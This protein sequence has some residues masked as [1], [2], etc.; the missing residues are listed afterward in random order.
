MFQDPVPALSWDPLKVDHDDFSARTEGAEDAGI[1]LRR[2][3]EVV[4]SIAGAWATAGMG[5]PRPALTSATRSLGRI[6]SAS[7][8][9]SLEANSSR[10][11]ASRS[12]RASGSSVMKRRL[13]S[14]GG[15]DFGS[16]SAWAAEVERLRAMNKSGTMRV[17]AGSF[18]IGLAQ[19]AKLCL[20]VGG[21]SFDG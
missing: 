4:V 20:S 14:D 11:S 7:M 21:G 16:F 19:R 8:I 15:S 5:A 10:L 13:I 2:V 3:L 17:M 12:S 9:S 6:L 18:P 1:G